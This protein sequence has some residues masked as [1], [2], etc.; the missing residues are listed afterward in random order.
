MLLG[1]C[2]ALFLV[3]SGAAAAP[4]A[5]GTTPGPFPPNNPAAFVTYE[6]D[7]TAF[8]PVEGNFQQVL[9]QVHCAAREVTATRGVL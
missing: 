2:A 3:A 8:I 6:N 4:T 1:I 5:Q 9:Q 7:G